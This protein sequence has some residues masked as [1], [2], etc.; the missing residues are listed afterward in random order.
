MISSEQVAEARCEANHA[1]EMTC[2]FNKETNSRARDTPE[3]PSPP[4]PIVAWLSYP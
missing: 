1:A 2:L 4:P 3:R